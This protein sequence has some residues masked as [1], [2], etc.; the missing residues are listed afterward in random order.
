MKGVGEGDIMDTI[1]VLFPEI[2]EEMKND[3]VDD[4]QKADIK[5]KFSNAVGVENFGEDLF[6]CEDFDTFKEENIDKLGESE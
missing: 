1:G 4:E 2:Q 3:E 5:V 6:G